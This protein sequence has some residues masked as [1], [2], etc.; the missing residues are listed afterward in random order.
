MTAL[1][2]IPEN[3]HRRAWH[4][5]RVMYYEARRLPHTENVESLPSRITWALH[6]SAFLQLSE[7]DFDLVLR[8]W[9]QKINNSKIQTQ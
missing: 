8:F 1:Q 4:C 6:A 2:Q 3:L 5:L 9:E 7:E